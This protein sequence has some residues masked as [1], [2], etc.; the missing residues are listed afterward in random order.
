MAEPI[1]PFRY[2]WNS[3]V[4]QNAQQRAAHEAARQE[5][6]RGTR[7]AAW[8]PLGNIVD[9]FGG[10]VDPDTGARLYSGGSSGV[11]MPIPPMDA[12]SAQAVARM[13]AAV[14]PRSQMSSPQAQSAYGPAFAP[15]APPPQP[16][17]AQRPMPAGPLAHGGAMPNVTPDMIQTGMSPVGGSAGPS[18]ESSYAYSGGGDPVS[19]TPPPSAA[20]NV[21]EEIMAN[22]GSNAPWLA[23]AAAGF[24]TAAGTSPHAMV[25]IGQ[26][27]LKGLEFYDRMTD[28]AARD[29]LQA[30]TAMLN[31][32]QQDRQA[33]FR[34]QE[35]GQGERR[36]GYEGQRVENE[37]LNQQQQR[38]NDRAKLLHE[39]RK[40]DMEA[41]LRRSQAGYYD[42]HS[43]YYS[44]QADAVPD[45][46]T[47]AEERTLAAV[48]DD[49]RQRA[50]QLADQGGGII[51][52]EKAQKLE[53]QMLLD[54]ALGNNV[55]PAK[56][57][58][59]PPAPSDP[60]L[61]RAGRIY[62]TKKG[63]LRWNGS[64]FEFPV[65]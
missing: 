10:S 19:P 51:D 25:N 1:S 15:E 45:K 62:E 13:Q 63:P 28:R 65:R 6:I 12:Q 21:V 11:T 17:A 64:E 49:A 27:G 29:R 3:G 52:T 33:G 24:G 4:N 57:G 56:L 35:L 41:P 23:L 42:A 61:M 37:R 18:L 26:G 43:K 54:W 39:E 14:Q 2:W 5:A 32:E 8:N 44:A 50:K 46:T 9:F 60:R 48:R 55:D 16:A 31:A 7:A 40:L 59:F 30:A 22:R 58:V 38:E 47:I 53:K 20:R 36:L 34:Q